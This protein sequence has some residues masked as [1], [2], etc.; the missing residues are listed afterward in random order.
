MNTLLLRFISTGAVAQRLA[1][2]FLSLIALALVV[3]DASG[4]SVSPNACALL[5]LIVMAMIAFAIHKV[6]GG[7]TSLIGLFFLG[8]IL[9]VTPRPLVALFTQDDSIYTLLFGET[10]APR[11]PD[12]YRLLAFWTIGVSSLYGGYFLFFKEQKQSLKPLS[13]KGR[14]Y[15]KLS[16]AVA[17]VIT[18]ILLPLLART[19]FVAFATGGY[20]A[21]YLNQAESSFS[22]LPLLGYL[23]PAL[24]A[25]AVII[26]EKKYTRLMVAAVVCYAFCGILFGRRME[27]GTW[28]LVALWHQSAVRGKPIR[29]GRLFLGF[30]VAGAAFQ[31]IEMMRSESDAMN[32][33][34]LAF[35]TSQGVIFMIPALAWQLAPPPLH[36]VLGSLLSVRHVYR[37][38]DIG[39]IG[40]ANILDYISSQ[41]GPTLF[42]T[43]NGLSSTGYLDVYY[44]S[45]EVLVL[46]T[47]GCGLLGF[48]L[49]KW[50][51]GSFKSRVSLFFLCVSLPSLFF[52]QRSSV[53]TVTS[54]VVYLAFFMVG[55]YFLHRLL[56]LIGRSEIARERVHA[57]I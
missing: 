7:V 12:L 48:L 15:C 6:S 20:N 49:R 23:C 41:S 17:F 3:V 34:L 53:F 45:G 33:V 11:G 27:V 24:Y 9:W 14:T 1:G 46:Y 5:L 40:T 19:R 25:L 13:S 36:T 47:L 26:D 43:G 8:T 32:L 16:F 31:W 18:A 4:L 30:M 29:M 52:V 21:L 22:L 35:F 2:A 44:L 55:T 51:V 57:H 42:A 50:E 38:F 28:L 54:Q 56:V 39:S 10:A 37:L